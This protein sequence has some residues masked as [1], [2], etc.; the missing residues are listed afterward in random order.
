MATANDVQAAAAR[1]A[2]HVLRTPLLKSVPLTARSGADVR[3]KLE[4]EQ[5]TGSFKIRGATNKLLE[6]GATGRGVVTA[7]SGNHGLAMATALSVLGSHGT[8]VLP[9]NVAPT[10]RAALAQYP[11]V[12]IVL[13]GAD[14]V[15]AETHA[16]ALA[17]STGSDFV[18]PYN[19]RSYG[20]RHVHAQLRCI[21][22]TRRT[23]PGPRRWAIARQG[24]GGSGHRRG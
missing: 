1:I 2:G 4:S 13:H 8:V 11:G 3:L 15:D 24:H 6:L 12:N 10:K 17:A 18:S 14:C 9:T 23:T 16:R 20:K 21:R 7:S 22:M 5:L 19:D